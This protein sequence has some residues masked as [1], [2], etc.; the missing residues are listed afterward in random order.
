MDATTKERADRD[1]FTPLNLASFGGL[2]LSRAAIMAKAAEAV[3]K[4][5][6]GY[7][8]G[9]RGADG[10]DGF[11]FIRLCA[12]HAT[13]SALNDLYGYQGWPDEEP[14]NE[15]VA[16]MLE[17]WG[18]T[19]VGRYDYREFRRGDVIVHVGV[20]PTAEVLVSPPNDDRGALLAGCWAPEPPKIHTQLARLQRHMVRVYR[21]TG[22]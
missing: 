3:V 16:N 1:Q 22:A 10:V 5:G 20:G 19:Q 6:I 8:P 15:R 2:G 17:E 18:L 21:W 4:A 13:H 11:G 14:W 9:G 12:E 7:K